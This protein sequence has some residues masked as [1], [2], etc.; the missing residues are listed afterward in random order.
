MIT[1]GTTV[2]TDEDLAVIAHKVHNET[3]EDWA[4][5]AFNYRK[6]GIEAVLG[7]IARHRAAYLAAKDAPGYQ[8]AAAREAQ[9]AV[10]AQARADQAQADYDA[11]RTPVPDSNA[12]SVP[13]LRDDV[14][15]LIAELKSL[16]VIV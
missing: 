13:A 14:N 11:R 7:K 4:T 16:G 12:V 5:R 8:P 3:P 9:R 1:L 6:G 15:A 2:I 10:E